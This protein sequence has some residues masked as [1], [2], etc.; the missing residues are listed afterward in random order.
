M[1]AGRLRTALASAAL[2]LTCGVALTSCMG[3]TAQNTPNGRQ[4][5]GPTFYVSPPAAQEQ[6]GR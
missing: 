1:R 6:G 3:Y 2:T 5:N 4:M